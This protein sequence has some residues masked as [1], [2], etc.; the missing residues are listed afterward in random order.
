VSYIRNKLLTQ[1]ITMDDLV[2]VLMYRTSDRSFGDAE[3]EDYERLSRSLHGR[4]CGIISSYE[5]SVSVP[6]L[7]INDLD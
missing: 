5:A 1:G 4:M 7:S 3:D 2:K 6:D